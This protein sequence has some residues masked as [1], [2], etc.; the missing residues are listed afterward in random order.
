MSI[1]SG[2]LN[3]V[4]ISAK[5][6]TPPFKV[7]NALGTD[8]VVNGRQRK[9]S[10]GRRGGGS[11]ENSTARFASGAMSNRKSVSLGISRVSTR[12]RIAGASS[13]ADMH[14]KALSS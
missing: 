8:A 10:D 7:L 9:E 14:L 5:R 4:C 12:P 2:A 6:Q 11:I 1:H 3:T 13:L